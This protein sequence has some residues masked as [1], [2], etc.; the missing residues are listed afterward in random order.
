M[1]KMCTK[2]SSFAPPFLLFWSRPLRAKLPYALAASLEPGPKPIFGKRGV[3][4][5]DTDQNGR[6]RF[7]RRAV[8]WLHSRPDYRGALP[9]KDVHAFN[10]YTE[11]SKEKTDWVPKR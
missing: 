2:P 11:F 4:V 5:R 10:I 8:P 9:L 3:G 1:D 7:K 6:T